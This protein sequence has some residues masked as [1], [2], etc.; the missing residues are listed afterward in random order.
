MPFLFAT[1]YIPDENA[2]PPVD[3]GRRGEGWAIGDHIVFVAPNCGAKSPDC[4]SQVLPAGN[5][6]LRLWPFGGSDKPQATAIEY[7]ATISVFDA[8]AGCITPSSVTYQESFDQDPTNDQNDMFDYGTEVSGNPNDNP[9]PSGS[10]FTVGPDAYRIAGIAG[11]HAS[12]YG[13]GDL[14]TYTITTGPTTKAVDIRL[15]WSG[16]AADHL[17]FGFYRQSGPGYESVSA[18]WGMTNPQYAAMPVEPSSTYLLSV[19]A[20]TGTATGLPYDVTICGST[21]P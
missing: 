9:E 15:A 7:R 13:H 20:M 18:G 1:L 19:G 16:I 4:E 6:V 8:D 5:Y 14:D 17:Y 11:T 10:A 3:D 12:D 2:N 21:L